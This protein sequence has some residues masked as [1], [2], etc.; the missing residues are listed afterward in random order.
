MEGIPPIVGRAYS[1][2]VRSFDVGLYEPCVIM[3]RKCIEAVCKELGATKGNLKQRLSAL[4]DDGKIDQNLL[5]WADQLRLIGNDA[6]HDLE[7]VIEQIDARDALDFV[8][9]ILMYV[10]TLNRRFEEFL[11]RRKNLHKQE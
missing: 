4:G 10:F 5:A 2:A 6:A 8:E 7:I 1:N 3:S 11:E 9:A